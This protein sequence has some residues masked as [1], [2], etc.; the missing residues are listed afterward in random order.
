MSELLNDKILEGV[1][2]GSNMDSDV[3]S[4]LRHVSIVLTERIIATNEA[5]SACQ[6]ITVNIGAESP[7]LADT[8]ARIRK[9]SN[10]VYVTFDTANYESVSILNQHTGE[11]RSRLMDTLSFLG[12]VEVSVNYLLG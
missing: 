4:A 5:L 1:S 11:I 2:G 7:L 3:A 12:Y 8:T 9:S 6:E 10:T